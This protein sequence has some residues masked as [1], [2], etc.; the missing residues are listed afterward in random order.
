MRA[1][2]C[3]ESGEPAL[4]DVPEP[5]GDGELVCVLACGLCGS[6]IEKLLPSFAGRVL[7][8]EVVAETATGQRVALVHHAPCGSC[9]RCRAGH[10]TT[11][12]QF[13]HETILPGGFAE[14]A[15]ANAWVDISDSLEDARATA[16]EPLACVLR[17]A[18]SVPN[19]RV[20]VVGQGFMGRLFAQVLEQRGDEVF[21]VD[22]D[23][24]REGR[25][26]DGPVDAAVL[27]APGGADI[28]L[29][30]LE[31]GGTLLCFADP[32]AI[33][34][35]L[36]YRRELTVVGS[37]SATPRHMETAAALLPQLDLPAPT[38]LPLERFA[39]GLDLQ[40]RGEALKVVFV[41]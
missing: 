35:E 13:Q 8:H 16:V 29:A 19:G 15:R 23:A 36:V 7:G 21:A 6:D 37:R 3:G 20:L 41:P 39:E 18:E 25:A 14:R 12:S 9:A 34:A 10:E 24:R 22:R 27:C 1:V 2:V 5:T 28:A 32:G 38:V 26:P 17:G 4:E 40:R 33:P 31:P 30:A 11:C